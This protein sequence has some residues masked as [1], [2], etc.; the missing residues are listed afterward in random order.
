MYHFFKWVVYRLIFFM[1]AVP[2][3]TDFP[4]LIELVDSG[5]VDRLLFAIGRVFI[6]L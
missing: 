6:E 1:R 2:L 5:P 4:K 3:I